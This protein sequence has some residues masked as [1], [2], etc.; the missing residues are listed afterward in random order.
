L[1][2]VIVSIVVDPAFG[3]R[4]GE[5]A[6]RGPVW[7]ADTEVNRAAAERWWSNHPS[8]GTY[9]GVTTFLVSGR[10]SP[11]EWCAEVLPTVDMH[12]GAYDDNP[13][14]YDAIDVFGA[15]PTPT[16]RD[17]FATAGYTSIAT[18]P[19]GF[20]VSRAVRAA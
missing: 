3:E 2:T 15:S 6:R 10:E 12:Y 13:P 5:I 11:E 7:I 14:M 9:E 4:L 17:L 18:L 19:G 1:A 16:L 20:R 8:P